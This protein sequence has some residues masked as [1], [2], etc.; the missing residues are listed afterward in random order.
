MTAV[1]VALAALAG[2]SGAE[3]AGTS[4]ASQWA[5]AVSG[6]YNAPGTM[7]FGSTALTAAVS[8]STD[9]CGALT[10]NQ[11]ATILRAPSE[12]VFYTPM[13]PADAIAVGQC[14][15]TGRTATRTV[16]FNK[17]VIAPVFHVN[18]LDASTLRFSAGPSGGTIGLTTLSKDPP[19]NL[20]GGNTLSNSIPLGVAGCSNAPADP[21]DNS[22][23]GSFRLAE[24]GGP[25]SSFMTT[26]SSASDDGWI[27]TL[28]F[29]T[30]PLTKT[31]S[32]A[33][34]QNGGTSHLTFTIT[35][36]TDPGQTALSPLDF[37]DALPAGL[38]IA[39]STVSDNGS[40][41]SPTVTDASGGALT[42]SATGVRASNISLAV[43]ATCTIT[44]DVTSTSPGTYVNDNSN[45]SSTVGNVVPNTRTSLTVTPAADLSVVKTAMSSPA[46]PGTSM[47][48]QLV[49]RN[50]GPDTAVNASV[51]DS[52]P[53]GLTFVSASPGCSASGQS[54]TCALGD[55]AT[56]ASKTLTVNAAV[57][58][59]LDAGTLENTATTTSD[60]GDPNPGNNSSTA[61]VPVD[62]QA[63]LQIVKRALSDRLVPGRQLS[64]ELLVYNNGPSPARG[65]RVSD[66]LPRGLSFVSASSGCTFA[67]GTVACT[68]DSLASGGSITFRV[69]TRVAASVTENSVTNTATV[70]STTRDPDPGNNRDRET[71][72]SG[73][74]ADLSITKIPSVDRVAVGGQLFYTLL[75]KNDGPSD[76]QN[77][78]VADD[79]DAGL[80]L[81]SASGSQGSSCAVAASRVTCRLGTLAAGGSA[82]VLVSAR[83]DAAGELSNSATVDSPTKDPDPRDNRD[84][85]RVTGDPP[86]ATAPQMAD[87]EIVKTSNR[88]TL[89]GSGTIT[90]TL[91]VTNH[92]PGV[93]SGVQVLDTPSLPIKV[94]SIRA[95]AGR[96]ATTTPIRCDL[97]TLAN[98][99]TATVRVVA[100]PMAPGT[101]RNSAS[102][103]SDVP[104]PNPGNNIDSTSTKVQGLLKITKVA[105]TKTV[106]AGGTLSY[107]I[108]V[109][110][111]SSFALRS[112]RVCDDLP[113]GLVYV[114]STPKAKLSKGKYCWAISTLGAKKSN[115]ITIKARAL[116]G[117]GGR[118]VNVATATAPG[119]RGARGKAATGT[120][121]IRVLAAQRRG[122][123]VTG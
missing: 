53:A 42:G 122:G 92:G 68:A 98:G 93:A 36:P 109:T 35:N 72:P 21:A 113:S 103:T 58:W 66:L 96:C 34:V 24:T 45:L 110:N 65:V 29:P 23:C 71:V 105:S 16:S 49:V 32:P 115:A 3:A 111:A 119:A 41:G 11:V 62:P 95:S 2:A 5:T 27:W 100:Q 13:P 67:S 106:R 69:T 54:V 56:G 14:L 48:Y 82:Q 40:C 26:N 51:S 70:T 118:T 10:N 99:A 18:N 30:A 52:L 78:V 61:R 64:Y 55:L 15:A 63:D 9:G 38:R 6:A 74:E 88:R 107:R 25:V 116:R 81:L 59:S 33:T 94:R 47:S 46:V 108:T 7:M 79:A 112:V 89:V 121:A 19:L 76:A 44:V 43:G 60:T 117:Q 8:G 120:A 50:S 80:T 114:S 57:A 91:K 77:V 73:P 97:G 39:S 85:R 31:F 83:A 12:A 87:L 86:P 75:V 22:G 84:E 101:L 17:P 28:S 1:V 4:G 90:Y 20:V 123:G 104:D 37:T 102:V